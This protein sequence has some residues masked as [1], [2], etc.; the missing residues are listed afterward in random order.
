MKPALKHLAVDIKHN[1]IK[2][3]EAVNNTPKTYI[4]FE[5]GTVSK[6]VEKLRGIKDHQFW[7]DNRNASKEELINLLEISTVNTI[8]LSDKSIR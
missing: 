3:I 5:K 7:L 8:K 1:M 6:L 4:D 2:Q